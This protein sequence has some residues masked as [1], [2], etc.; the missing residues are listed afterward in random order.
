MTKH[1]FS[2]SYDQALLATR[3]MMLE[4]EGYLV[5]SALGLADG[6]AKCNGNCYDL[7]VIGHSIPIADK[8]HLV[9]HFRQ[10]GEAPVL[11]LLRAGENEVA[12]DFYT[13]SDRPEELLRM[14]ALILQPKAEIESRRDGHNA[15]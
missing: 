4:Q 11:S 2:I 7:F 6:I 10:H 12:A 15:A 1:I 14:V 3:Q 5:T 13:Y 9:N 8:E